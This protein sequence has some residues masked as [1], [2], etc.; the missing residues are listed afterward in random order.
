[1]YDF[2]VRTG[3]DPNAIRLN[4]TGA[5]SKELD[6]QGNLVLHTAAG[7]V[8][9]HAPVLYQDNGAA[10]QQIAGPYILGGDG[11]VRCSV[12]SYDCTQPLIIDPILS[13]STYLGNSS[14]GGATNAAAIAS[15]KDG[16]AYIT[17]STST[18]EFPKLSALQGL[19]ISNVGNEAFVTKLNAA[20]QLVYSTYLGG[21]PDESG[22][23]QVGV[24]VN[25]LPV[26]GGYQWIEINGTSIAV[27]QHGNVCVTGDALV[28]PTPIQDDTFIGFSPLVNAFQ[29][30][31]EGLGANA[32]IAKLDSSGS[33]LVY[34]SYVG[35]EPNIVGAS[36]TGIA[37]D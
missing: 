31:P 16:N 6:A 11:G 9:E 22:V 8:V 15:D 24:D 23:H 13:Y 21:I 26:N 33:S 20:G 19:F 2:I 36:A 17:G 3:G 27:D 25:G 34:S 4:I 10:R 7:D 5:T 14:M 35:G 28:D 30:D 18:L 37:V 12:G 1:E 29:P 32:W